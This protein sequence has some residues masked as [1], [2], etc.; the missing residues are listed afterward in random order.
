MLKAKQPSR[1]LG[2]LVKCALALGL[3]W[4][5]PAQA[6]VKCAPAA[7]VAEFLEVNGLKKTTAAAMMDG[8]MLEAWE[9]EDLIIIVILVRDPANPMRCMIRELPIK[10]EGQGA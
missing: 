6:Q 1:I 10:R 2:W 3:F 8:D 5:S 4:A 7:I 9:K